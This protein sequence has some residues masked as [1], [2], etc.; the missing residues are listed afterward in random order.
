MCMSEISRRQAVSTDEPAGS[1]WQRFK[2][3]LLH[4]GSVCAWV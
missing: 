4:C 2:A 3:I 1:N